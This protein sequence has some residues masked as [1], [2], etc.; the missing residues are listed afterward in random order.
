M[1]LNNAIIWEHYKAP[2]LDKISQQLSGATCFSMLDTKD[3]FWS[4]HLDEK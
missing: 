4:I 1:D 3:G 2:T